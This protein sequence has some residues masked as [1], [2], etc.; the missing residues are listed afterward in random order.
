MLN[1]ALTDRL[2]EFDRHGIPDQSP[3]RLELDWLGVWYEG[4]FSREP[5]Q[6]G[7]LPKREPASLRW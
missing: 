2:P 5:L 1:N 3:E 7:S 4:V 6:D